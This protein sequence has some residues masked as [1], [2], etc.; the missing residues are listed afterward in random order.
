M[1]IDGGCHCGA[2]TYEAEVNPEHTAI[3][4]CTDCQTLSG[5]AF[6]TLIPARGVNYKILSGKPKEYIKI[7]T[8]GAKRIQ[9]FCS[10]CGS[11]L[12]STSLDEAPEFYNIRLGTVRQRDRLP[13]QAPR[14]TG[15][16]PRPRKPTI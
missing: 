12:Y 10:D 6:R 13:S 3:C 7:G 4:H 9:S 15:P 16:T 1:K 5:T 2:I 8:S 11:P 14:P